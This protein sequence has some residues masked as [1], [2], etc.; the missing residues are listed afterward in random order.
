MSTDLRERLHTVDPAASDRSL[1]PAAL[2]A[3]ARRVLEDAAAAAP[4]AGAVS[5]RTRGRVGRVGRWAVPA[6][7]A[8][9]LAALLAPALTR[10]P[11][12]SAEAASLLTRAAGAIHTS[13]PAAAP[14]QWWR[15]SRTGF[16]LAETSPGAT[17]DA[18][19]G[20]GGPSAVLVSADSTDYLAVDG[21]RPGYTVTDATRILRTLSGLA[22]DPA[23][24]TSPARTWTSDL[25]PDA[26]PG[27]WQTPSPEFVA[28]LPLDPQA[29]RDALYAAAAGH[30]SSA[31]GEAFVYAAD[32][33]RT[34]LVPADL[35]AALYRVLAT[36]PGVEV[37]DR[38][39]AVGAR[40]GV[41][42][43]YSEAV[44]GIRQEIVVDPAT[45]ELVGEREVA[46]TAL[47]GIPAGT[48]I[49]ESAVS[50][51]VVDAVPAAVVQSAVHARCSAQ[52]DGAVACTAG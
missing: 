18:A 16:A 21:S 17:A 43:S 10:A 11:S 9:T 38:T 23:V 42:L 33:L 1:D 32:L 12:A 30:G 34:G 52:P 46:V 22:W 48:V 24:V 6:V 45:G 40:S 19:A 26:L 2:R 44:D 15:I 4:A 3:M 29:L 7:A 20:G 8:L 49:G 27:S 39:A 14:D 35:R 37:S 51:T 41:A 31:D 28:A 47:D 13:D 50:R 25:A 5:R 36:V